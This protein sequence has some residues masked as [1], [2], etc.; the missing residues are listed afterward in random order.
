MEYKWRVKKSERGMTLE[1]F[2]Y[3]KLGDWSH[4]QV[5]DAIDHKRAFVNGRNVFISK[6]NLKPNHVVLFAPSDND[7]PRENQSRYR[8]VDVLLE[9]NDIIAVNK[10]AFV[11]HEMMAETVR[12]YL[13]RRNGQK[14]YPYVGQ[15][16]RLDKETTGVM[17]FTKKKRANVLADQ[18][19]EHKIRKFYLA[20]VHGRV[21]KEQG[22][23]KNKIEKGR[24]DHGRKARET[25]DSDGMRAV[26]NFRVVERYDDATLLRVEIETGRTHQIRVHFSG[27][28]HP[29]IGDKLYGPEQDA[30]HNR[31]LL[32]AER[33]DFKHPV[34]GKKIRVMAPIPKD[35]GLV[36]EKMRD[37]NLLS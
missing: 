4:K 13:Q 16:H 5:K 19:R 14:S 25:T 27:M 9:D 1:N 37:G 21:E 2:I 33:V 31:H 15:M 17:L 29:L 34:S 8:F 3:K 28:D 30:G 18:F 23:I 22:V 10:P 36:I 7:V 11:D 6:W 26:T 24:F 20:L 32:H 12:N 35:M